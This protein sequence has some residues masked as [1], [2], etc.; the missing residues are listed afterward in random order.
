MILRTKWP[1]CLLA[2]FFNSLER[3]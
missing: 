1:D 2:Q 3:L